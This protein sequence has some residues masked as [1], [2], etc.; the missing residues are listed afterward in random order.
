M[1]MARGVLKIILSQ[2]H[3]PNNLLCSASGLCS[4]GDWWVTQKQISRGCTSFLP[5]SELLLLPVLHHPR[6]WEARGQ[7]FHS[8]AQLAFS[9][10]HRSRAKSLYG[11]RR[12]LSQL[13]GSRYS[14]T[15]WQG[16]S[17][18]VS[19][20]DLLFIRDNSAPHQIY[21]DLFEPV[22]SQFKQLA[23]KKGTWRGG[24]GCVLLR[25]ALGGHGAKKGW[26]RRGKF[27]AEKEAGTILRICLLPLGYYVIQV[28]PVHRTGVW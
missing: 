23:C 10:E 7:M 18:P 13:S 26:S 27:W 11:P 12:A 28:S 21:Y 14:L 22:L 16:A 5:P 4:S 8:W 2:P 9:S 25:A 17:D 15:L 20:E 6:R 3:G 19:V 24:V 1:N